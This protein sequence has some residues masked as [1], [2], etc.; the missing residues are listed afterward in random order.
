M[1]KLCSVLIIMLI[2]VSCVSPLAVFA[3]AKMF[4]PVKSDGTAITNNSIQAGGNLN[5]TIYFKD[6]SGSNFE[7]VG[8]DIDTK[9]G[10]LSS[11]P[12]DPIKSTYYVAAENLENS[13][14]VGKTGYVF[15][16]R[17]RGDAAAGY[18][19]VDFIITYDD[20]G[21]GGGSRF[22]TVVPWDV[23]IKESSSSGG[24]GTVGTVPK[25]L[26]TSFSTNPYEVVA[27]ED[28]TLT[29]TFKNTSSSNSAENLKAVLTSDGT[30]NPVSGSS[31][32]FIQS[33]A[34]GA[35][36]SQ[37]IKLHAKADAAP[38]SYSVS[39][40]MSFDAPG[41]KDPITDSETVAIPV[42]QVPKL[43]LTSIQTMGNMMVGSDLN[44]M[45]SVN[46]TGKATLYNVMA[47]VSDSSGLMSSEDVYLGNI[48]SGAS[49]NVDVYLS[50]L[51]AGD[52]KVIVE[53]TY[54]DENGKQYSTE[55]NLDVFLSEATGGKDDPWIEPEPVEQKK[56]ISPWIFVAGGAVAAGVA[57]LVI[58]KNNK[59]KK[60]RE[61]DLAAARALDE[62]Y[63]RDS[64]DSM[65]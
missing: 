33:L 20:S 3:E 29:V 50:A 36:S 23:L 17:C 45:T 10:V 55:T 34:P 44:I 58:V 53:V 54:E 30:F 46:N 22:T 24:S 62:K 2:L 43:Q 13:S 35:S 21:D 47:K 60:Q 57:A 27:G 8:I 39:F 41:V 1:K 64:E 19:T 16:M 12:F 61:R 26:I 18:Y 40:A 32:L 48:Q 63:F 15:D 38:G 65:S 37:S 52:T 25:I 4:I 11:F 56:G 6:V 59:K 42:K 28:F 31:T 9:G 51:S 5:E 14:S 7:I 49:G